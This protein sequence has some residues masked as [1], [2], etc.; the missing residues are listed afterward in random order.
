M[1]D[2]SD[3]SLPILVQAFMKKVTENINVI[4]S[5]LEESITLLEICRTQLSKNASI[6]NMDRDQLLAHLRSLPNNNNKENKT[7]G[8]QKGPSSR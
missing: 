5:A 4:S 8:F 1:W 7:S 2:I 3:D 6:S